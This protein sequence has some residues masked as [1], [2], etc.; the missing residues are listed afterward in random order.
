MYERI[1]RFGWFRRDWRGL[2]TRALS[3]GRRHAKRHAGVM[4]MS[5]IRLAQLLA[6]APAHM[7]ITSVTRRS[8]TERV[9]LAATSSPS[10]SDLP[11]KVATGA[12]ATSSAG[13]A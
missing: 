11:G 3:A 6:P 12:V 2:C 1:G 7:A 4:R 8:Q 13:A 10:G 5:Q 9:E